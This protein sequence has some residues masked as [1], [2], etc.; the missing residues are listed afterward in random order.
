[1]ALS[2]SF[3]K[4]ID[5]PLSEGARVQAPSGRRKQLYIL[6]LLNDLLHHVKHH[7]NSSK[8]PP[9]EGNIQSPLIHLFGF[10][11]A[12]SIDVYPNHHEKIQRL[13]DLW[14]DNGYFQSLHITKLR[15]TVANAAKLGFPFAD[16]ETS[17]ANTFGDE[18]LGEEK[19]EA[20]YIMPASH[21]DSMTPFYDLP[22]ANMLPHIIPNSA[23]PIKPQLVKPLQLKEGPAD[24][25]LSTAVKNF[26]RN[27]DSL[28]EA[29]SDEEMIVDIDELG[30]YVKR[31]EITGDVLEGDGY[32]GWSRAFCEKMKRR[33]AG[34]RR[35]P[36][37]LGRDSSFDRGSIA[38]RQKNDDSSSS[39]RSRSRSRSWSN[40]SRSRKVIRRRNERASISRSRSRSRSPSRG[41]RPYRSLR[42]RSHSMSRSLSYSPPP[43]IS[44]EQEPLPS[45]TDPRPLPRDRIQGMSPLQPPSFAHPLSQGLPP[46]GP[47]G[48]PVPPPP[49]PNYRGP[50]PPPPPPP[51]M[52]QSANADHVYTTP[53]LP[54]PPP[55]AVSGMYQDSGPP[56]FPPGS[57]GVTQSQ[58]P[59]GSGSWGHPQQQQQHANDAFPHGV[60]GRGRGRAQAPVGGRG[61]GQPGWHR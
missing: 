29:I 55:P 49:P 57:R 13:L 19:K 48:L 44:T 45:S 27:I 30:Q 61:F 52:V 9:L 4:T 43:V 23:T 17:T 7:T 6:Y 54:P 18:G 56:S 60:R 15:E 21:G 8:Y 50:W 41:A 59:Q 10:V 22:A 31:D 51:P 25:D 40:S 53:P 26:L 58:L 33:G 2:G 35:V 24:E 46:L 36:N 11:S 28:D 14:D 20:P 3:V 32:Y 12:Y 5:H 39:G 34:F 38:R 42:S 47:G 16:D 1:M 37:A